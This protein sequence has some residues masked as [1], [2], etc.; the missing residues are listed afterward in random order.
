[1]ID[2]YIVGVQYVTF[3]PAV[4]ITSLIGGLGAGL[5]S[6]VLSVGAAAFFVASPRLSF[7]IENLSDLLTTL[8]FIL[9][10]FCNVVLIAGIRFAVERDRDLN[11]RLE[12]HGVTLR[13][14]E[15]RLAVVGAELQHRTRN[16]ISIVGT[17]A[18]NTLRTSETLGDFKARYHDRLQALARAQGLLFRTKEGGRV[19]FDELLNAELA[20]H[21]V[22][23][24][25]NRLITLDGPK[26]V[27]LRS[28]TV[29][30]LAMVVHELLANATKHGA[31]SS[32][33]GI[34]QSDGGEEPREKAS[35]GFAS[36]GRKAA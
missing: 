33:M 1:V 5:F 19:T 29:Q 14:T 35:L 6:L 3:F 31:L 8:L 11:Q 16:L 13:E 27:R 23:V 26:G 7:Y 34:S 36:I 9:L 20:A 18:D 21:S 28:G 32:R 24:E 22:R 10:T 4:I 15:E 12:Q 17:I 25:D 2:P 30:T